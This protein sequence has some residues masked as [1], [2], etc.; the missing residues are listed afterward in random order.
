MHCSPQIQLLNLFGFSILCISFR[1]KSQQHFY[2]SKKVIV[3]EKFRFL[4]YLATKTNFFTF[5]KLLLFHLK[6]E[7]AGPK[8]TYKSNF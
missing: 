6:Q 7:R 2:I 8:C 3:F 4:E 1:L 5:K